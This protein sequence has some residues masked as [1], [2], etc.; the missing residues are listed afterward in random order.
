MRV[1]FYLSHAVNV[2]QKDIEKERTTETK[3]ER[4]EI[5]NWNQ[6]L[7][8]KW[9]TINCSESQAWPSDAFMDIFY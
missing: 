4:K 9:I 5:F 1:L 3:D 6:Y 2:T 7:S 8:G